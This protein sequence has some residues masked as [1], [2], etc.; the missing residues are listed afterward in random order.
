MSTRK[1]LVSLALTLAFG[2]GAAWAETPGLGK[3]ITEADIKPWNLDVLP[4]GTNL[5]P[6]SGTPAQG[7]PIY[8]QKCAACHGEKGEKPAPGYGP[9]VGAHKFDR[10]D[11]PKT[12]TYYEFATTLFDVIRRS[13][14]YTTPRTL[15]DNEVYALSAY[16]LSINKLIGENDAMDAQSLPKVKMPNAGKFIVRFPDRI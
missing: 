12:V 3:T 13:M 9:M 10:I 4:D 2:A 15:T 8:A 6:G 14:P 11:A 16:I 5:P 7:A 1:L